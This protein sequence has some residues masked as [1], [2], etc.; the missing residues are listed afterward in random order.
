MLIDKD[1]DG[2]TEAHVLDAATGFTTYTR[3]VRTIL[4]ATT[5]STW[6]IAD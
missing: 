2:A 6:S 4:G 5:D 3:Q 1:A